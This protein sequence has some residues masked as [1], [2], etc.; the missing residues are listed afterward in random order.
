MHHSGMEGPSATCRHLLDAA[1]REN[2]RLREGL[3][4]AAQQAAL[5]RAADVGPDPLS[6][7]PTER[8]PYAVDPLGTTPQ[9]HEIPPDVE[10]PPPIPRES[11]STEVATEVTRRCPA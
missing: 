10:P 9:R 1:F 5:A 8:K 2:A 11:R 6:S 3:L 7:P 4:D